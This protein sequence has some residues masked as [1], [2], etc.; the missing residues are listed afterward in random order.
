MSQSTAGSSATRRERRH[1]TANTAEAAAPTMER[2]TVPALSST[3]H[4][5][6]S[7]SSRRA[8]AGRRARS[9]TDRACSATTQ[10]CGSLQLALVAIGVTGAR[11]SCAAFRADIAATESLALIGR[12]YA[13]N[14][15]S[16]TCATPPVPATRQLSGI[17]SR[18]ARAPGR[19]AGA[20][21]SPC[22]GRRARRL[23]LHRVPHVVAGGDQ[24]AG[25]D[26]SSS[27]ACTDSAELVEQ[28]TA[29]AARG[30]HGA[31]PRERAAARPLPGELADARDRARRGLP[32]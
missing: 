24:A 28:A 31:R 13:A 21:R 1:A 8:R 7:R 29:I 12:R 5:D 9:T 25:V 23:P 11:T 6:R 22:R 3:H 4:R 19:D 27:P 20:R 14:S 15:P 30:P 10:R 17:E 26:A 16:T 2:M 18:G 32:V